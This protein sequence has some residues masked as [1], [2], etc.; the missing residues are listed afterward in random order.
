M[1]NLRPSPPPPPA[2]ARY[3]IAPRRA[4]GIGGLSR[5][6][7]S[8]PE[9]DGAVRAIAL[10]AF[11]TLVL[12]AVPERVAAQEVTKPVLVAG[13]MLD[14][15]TI[16]PGDEYTADLAGSGSFTVQG[17]PSLFQARRSGSSAWATATANPQQSKG[18][19][20]DGVYGILF[21]QSSGAWTYELDPEKAN[22]LARAALETDVFEVRAAVAVR[23]SPGIFSDTLMITIRVIGNPD[24]PVFTNA[25]PAQTAVAGEMFSYTI[26]GNTFV[27]PDS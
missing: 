2:S 18:V 25:I 11:T 20:V 23:D 12:L 4:S 9:C 7:P 17:A 27:D 21:L 1:N 10:M 16:E 8:L 24:R 3:C 5:T 19:P 22:G 26:P 13:A 15:S 14:D 6:I